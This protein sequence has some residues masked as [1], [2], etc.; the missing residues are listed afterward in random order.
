[1]NEAVE[2][3]KGATGYWGSRYARERAGDVKHSLADIRQAKECLG[4]EP[5]VQFREGVERTVAWYKNI[6]KY[7]KS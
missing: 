1:L 4:Y 2:I 6:A 5:L 7:T 3:L